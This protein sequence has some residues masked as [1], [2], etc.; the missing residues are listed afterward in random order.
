MEN[1]IYLRVVPELKDKLRAMAKKQGLS[2]T[3]LIVS[4]CWEK[5]K[6]K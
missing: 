1:H 4:I 3:A 5:V 2:L 6:E